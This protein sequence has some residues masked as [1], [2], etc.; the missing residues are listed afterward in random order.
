VKVWNLNN[1]GLLG[2][3]GTQEKQLV[4]DVMGVFWSP[5]KDRI[6]E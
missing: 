4:D 6:G 3:L 5:D 1:G 2:N